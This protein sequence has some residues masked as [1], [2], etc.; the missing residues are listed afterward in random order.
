M[1]FVACGR[2]LKFGPGL[3]L[4]SIHYEDRLVTEYPRCENEQLT[5]AEN[6]VSVLHEYKS[7]SMYGSIDSCARDMRRLP[8]GIVRCQT[9]F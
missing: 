4:H 7:G 8:V 2:C 6:N 1:C 3:Q 9:G 5:P